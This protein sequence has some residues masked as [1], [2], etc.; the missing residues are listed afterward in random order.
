MGKADEARRTIEE[1]ANRGLDTL[2][3]RVRLYQLAALKHDQQEMAKQVQAARRFPDGFLMVS[4]QTEVALFEGQLA[5]AFDLS[6]QFAAA[7]AAAGFTGS[8]AELWGRVAQSAA[9]FGDVAKAHT[10]VAKALAIDRTPSTALN[11]AFALAI[12]GDTA[13]ARK[14]VDEVAHSSEAANQEFETGIKLVEALLKVRQ[15]DYTAM[16]AF[17]SKAASDF[18]VAFM[19]AFAK[20][21]AGNFEEAAAQFKQFT[22]RNALVTAPL[23]VV[24]KLYNGRALVRAGKVSEGRKLYDQFFERWKDADQTLPILVAARQEYARLR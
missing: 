14:L 21:Q 1:A 20:L 11:C 10:A 15:G 13:A 6:G 17:A 9:A 7:S 8:A 23:V 24:A 2:R 5:R 22:E 4:T 12:A 18:G 3:V 16:D 19:L